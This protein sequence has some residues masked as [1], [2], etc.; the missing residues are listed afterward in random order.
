M[1]T[2]D[3]KGVIEQQI[4]SWIRREVAFPEKK[5]GKCEKVVVRHLNLEKKPQG[6]VATIPIRLEP[7][8]EDEIDPILHQI[9]DAAQTD[10]NDLKGGVQLY[11]VY[12]YFSGDR[13]YCPRKV[14][15]VAAEEEMERD[16]SPTEPPTEKGLVAQTMRHLE[17]VMRLTTI[18]STAN[19]QTLQRENARLSEMTERASQQQLD[20]MVLV[21][22]LLNEGTK[23]RLAERR[24]EAGLAMKEEAMSKLAALVPVI[25]NRV[26]GKPILPEEDKSFMLMS[27]FLENLSEEQQQQFFTGL[28]DTQ[29]MTLAEIL[30]EYEKKKSKWLE[31]QKQTILGKKNALPPPNPNQPTPID[32]VPVPTS[33]SM[34]DRMKG[35]QEPSKDPVL[36]QLEKDGQQFA[37]RFRDMFKPPT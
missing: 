15:R 34:Q 13:S 24:E 27:A 36:K 8:A 14:F 33:L 28:S 2:T 4:E 17:S 22:D 31:G 35:I 21:Q 6:D 26:A 30:A 16:V 18:S 11:A 3:A 20:L 1:A 23:R 37:S 10:A 7:G 9:A 25:I 29:K 19:L 32:A 5:L 12:A